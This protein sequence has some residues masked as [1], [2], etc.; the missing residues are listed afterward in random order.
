M[1]R[2]LTLTAV[3]LLS[4]VGAPPA[5]ALTCPSGSEP[6]IAA[7][8][9][10]GRNIGETLGV[11]DEDWAKFIDGVVTPRFPDGLSVFEIQGQWRDQPSGRIVREP[12][13]VL[14]LIIIDNPAAILKIAEIIALYKARHQQQSVLMTTAAICAAY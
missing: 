4:L 12:G 10:F 9:Y 14:K 2:T 5:T 6:R 1:R 11:S 13:K 3:A 7:E 8:L